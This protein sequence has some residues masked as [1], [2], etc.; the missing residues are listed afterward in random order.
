MS[1]VSLFDYDYTNINP[2]ISSTTTQLIDDPD[3]VTPNIHACVEYS[4]S[5]D[6]IKVFK[7]T[8]TP[9]K[10]CDYY[11]SNSATVADTGDT[12]NSVGIEGSGTTLTGTNATT[13]ECLR[14]PIGK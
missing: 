11:F 4:D 10:I 6:A 13:Y 7:T 12:L 3:R 2:E 1:V 5:I 9:T 14:C 8:A